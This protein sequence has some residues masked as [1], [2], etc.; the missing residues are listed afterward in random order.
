MEN[1]IEVK[2]LKKYFK[3][4]KAVDDISFTVEKG[5][6]FGFLGINGAGKSTTINML[7]TLFAPTAG[8]IDICG[9]RLGKEDEKIRESIGVVWQGN[10]LDDRLTV[11]ENLYV[12]GSLYG[13]TAADLKE[14]VERVCDRLQ[15]EDIYNRQYGKLSGGQKR[16]SELGAALINTPKILFLDEPTTGLDPATRKLVWESLDELR[17][18]DGMTVFLTTHYMEE[19]AKAGHIAIIDSGKIREFGTPFELKEKY[20]RDKLRLW[21]KPGR[22]EQ[23]KNVL[24][25]EC[26]R[27]TGKISNDTGEFQQETGTLFAALPGSMAAL[28]VLRQAEDDISGFELVQGSM[29]DVFLNV[30]GK[31]L[32]ELSRV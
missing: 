6:L 10:C 21:P 22:F 2:G 7:C 24:E 32:A 13:Y 3:E 23:V 26:R 29:D 11:K 19:A 14:N 31:S 4:V 12:R 28:P 16:R 17:K 25:D 18:E 9:C 5:E 27:W 20:A 1:M 8:E 15:L 30:T